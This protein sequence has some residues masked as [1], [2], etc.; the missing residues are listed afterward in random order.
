MVSWTKWIFNQLTTWEFYFGIGEYAAML[1]AK[2]SLTLSNKLLTNDND[3][4]RVKLYFEKKEK[5]V[6]RIELKFEFEL[7]KV[8]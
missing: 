5:R 3:N 8:K 1:E 4:D 6:Q 2:K 7:I